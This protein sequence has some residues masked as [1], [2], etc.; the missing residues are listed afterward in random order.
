MVDS[1]YKYELIV[2][3]FEEGG[4]DT[5]VDAQFPADNES[6]IGSAITKNSYFDE[7]VKW[8]RIKDD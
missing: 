4:F 8:I 5:F 7:G 6:S 1:I 3:R 2:E